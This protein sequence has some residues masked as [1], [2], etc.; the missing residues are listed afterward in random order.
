MFQ[1]TADHFGRTSDRFTER[2]SFT[3]CKPRASV[4]EKSQRSTSTGRFSRK[5]PGDFLD[6]DL[7][8]LADTQKQKKRDL[9]ESYSKL[10][11]ERERIMR[12]LEALEKKKSTISSQQPKLDKIIAIIDSGEVITNLNLQLCNLVFTKI[13]GANVNQ[14]P[15]IDDL[16]FEEEERMTCQLFTAGS[17]F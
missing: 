6:K 4:D 13:S 17:E 7:Q 10:M 8:E 5:S 14:M 9:Q 16:D 15:D 11:A 3:S 2:K 1:N 12:D